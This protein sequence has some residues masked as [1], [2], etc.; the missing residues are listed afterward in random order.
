MALK[1]TKSVNLFGE[2]IVEGAT[3]VQ[4]N[5]TVTFD[6]TVTSS[7]S[8]TVINNELY[9]ANK[10]E[11]REDIVEFKN[12][13]YELEDSAELEKSNKKSTP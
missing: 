4:L 6:K 3:A 12:M 8:E 2:S 9:L 1:S 10:R 7:Y 13:M 5:A 11:V